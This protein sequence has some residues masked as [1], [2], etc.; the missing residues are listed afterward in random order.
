[1]AGLFGISIGLD[2]SHT[3][4]QKGLYWGVLYGRHLEEKQCGV[5]VLS[6]GLIF[7]KDLP[8]PYVAAFRS[9]DSIPS[10]TEGVGY[11]GLKGD[12]FH[13][14]T[15]SK[16]G[17]YTVCFNGVISNRDRLI[18]E[19]EKDSHLFSDSKKSN[20]EIVAKVLAFGQDMDN[21]I[22]I[23]KAK[24]EGAYSLLVLSQEGIW[25]V[26]S[27]LGHWPLVIGSHP[28]EDAIIIA[29][30]S[31]GFNNLGFEIDREVGPGEFLLIKGG[32]P[33]VVV[34]GANEN[35]QRCSFYPVYT[36]HPAAK[37]N[38]QPASLV[39]KNLGACI[40]KRDIEGFKDPK[41]NLK[42][43]DIVT[44]VP[45]SGRCSA[46]GY[47]Q[48]YIRQANLGKISRI[49]FFDEVFFKYGFIRSYLG[50][51]QEERDERAHYKIVITAET[52]KDFIAMLREAGLIEMVNDI[53]E[54]GK[55]V[56]VLCDDSV[57]RGTQVR[58][59][60]VPKLQIIYE[61]EVDGIMIKVEIHVRASYPELLSHCPNSNTTKKG[62]SLA[63]SMP[64]LNERA[65]KLGVT[66]LRYTTREDVFQ[67]LGC[68]PKDLCHSCACRQE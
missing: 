33:V 25:V 54:S 63:E 61:A 49:P 55:I 40:A 27:S 64:D 41:S 9:K 37:I 38:G 50:E 35:S 15:C 53:F 4:F 44:L 36:S 43:V 56:V 59:N 13:V 30:E 45:D 6:Q 23:L 32:E 47:Y 22:Q 8:G 17:S 2:V 57:V 7:P 18:R 1:M 16:L 10:G 24:M 19:F 26:R 66:S 14:D 11:C 28:A 12:F 34:Q 31:T 67:V 52:I 60:L 62:E 65:K 29:S 21:A 5:S 20:A 51:S 42:R 39:R 46:I 68:D 48:E 58:G 3:F